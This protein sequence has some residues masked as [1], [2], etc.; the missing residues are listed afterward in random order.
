MYNDYNIM[1]RYLD[2]DEKFSFE[3]NDDWSYADDEDNERR[4][5]R[6]D[7]ERKDRGRKGGNE[8]GKAKRPPLK[9]HERPI[10]TDKEVLA[11]GNVF[12]SGP[13]YQISRVSQTGTSQAQTTQNRLS[14]CRCSQ[15]GTSQS[16]SSQ[17]STASTM[18]S[19][20]GTNAYSQT[21]SGNIDAVS[22]N[23]QYSQNCCCCAR[24]AYQQGLREG[25]RRGCCSCRRQNNC[26]CGC[27]NSF[28]F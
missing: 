12:A 21:S 26:Q 14:Q 11:T 7:D 25:F 20:A 24:S 9:P 27:Q 5:S 13:V 3:E 16:T 17:S 10:V 28:W 18:M 19:N 4:C 15:Y 6:K 2:C 1:T 22:S 8:K 23:S